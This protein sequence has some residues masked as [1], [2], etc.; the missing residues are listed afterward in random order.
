MSLINPG[1]N[2][3]FTNVVFD[4]HGTLTDHNERLKE[5]LRIACV[6]NG[7]PTELAR[8][9][10]L[11]LVTD[12]EHEQEFRYY[13]EKYIPA[14]KFNQ[15]WKTFSDTRDALFLP[16]AG[17]AETIET[18]KAMGV[19]ITFLTNGSIRNNDYA[20]S[21]GEHVSYSNI[22]WRVLIDEW[23]LFTGE[24][25]DIPLVISMDDL[26][27][28]PEKLKGRLDALVKKP[29]VLVYKAMKTIIS[30]MHERVFDP[31]E[32]LFITDYYQDAEF[33]RANG[34]PTALFFK[35]FNQYER[36]WEGHQMPGGIPNGTV[37]PYFQIQEIPYLC[38]YGDEIKKEMIRAD[39]HE[40]YIEARRN[41]RDPLYVIKTHFGELTSPELRV[42]SREYALQR[43][44][45]GLK[46][47]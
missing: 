45:N 31:K 47:S 12:M 42:V 38:V 1:T 20:R 6:E 39:V 11:G 25:D 16:V 19:S 13:V 27:F 4:F 46:L 9:I 22:M 34:M 44:Q 35:G 43:E 29:D 30:A 33:G 41:G 21:I 23:K 2:L 5:S 36:Y 17:L 8:S 7:L 10:V 32:T 24:G 28:T 18:L 14:E 26:R 15:F 3:K 37:M 40:F